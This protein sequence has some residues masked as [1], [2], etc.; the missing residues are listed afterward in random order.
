MTW[1]NASGL[2]VLLMRNSSSWRQACR[3]FTLILWNRANYRAFEQARHA[4]D[5]VRM[6]IADYPFFAGVP[7]AFVPRI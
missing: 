6:N 2:S 7:N 4:F 3:C 5:A 1:R